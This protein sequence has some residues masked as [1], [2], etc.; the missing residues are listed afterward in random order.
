MAGAFSLEALPPRVPAADAAARWQRVLATSR[1]RYARPRAEVEQ[2]L[3]E[4]E[5]RWQGA[6]T[7][8][9]V[10]VIDGEMAPALL[11]AADPAR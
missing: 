4:Q 3:L 9:E 8:P 2:A 7:Y 1:M 10:R 5:R 6:A 11:D